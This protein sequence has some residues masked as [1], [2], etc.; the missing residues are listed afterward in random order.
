[1]KTDPLLNKYLPDYDFNEVHA[2]TIHA[3][4]EKA[5][6]AIKE[7]KPSELSPLVHSLFSIRDLPARLMRKS[8]IKQ[9]WDDKPFLEQLYHEE[10]GFIP[11]IDHT[12]PPDISLENFTYYMKRKMDLLSGKY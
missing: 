1:M 11:T 3:S 2:V 9:K 7:M 6:I 8:F 5:F 12:V 10:G 4:P